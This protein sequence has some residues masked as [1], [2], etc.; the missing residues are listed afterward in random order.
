MLHPAHGRPDRANGILRAVW[1]FVCPYEAQKAPRGVVL[2]VRSINAIHRQP[3]QSFIVIDPQRDI[4]VIPILVPV[5][6]CH[7]C[8]LLVAV[9]SD[10]PFLHTPKNAQ[11][12]AVSR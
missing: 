12:L 4:P 8:L 2:G 7:C 11:G 6:L 3:M 5:E 10:R 1:R 9:G